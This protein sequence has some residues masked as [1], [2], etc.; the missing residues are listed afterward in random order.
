MGGIRNI[1]GKYEGRRLLGRPKWRWDHKIT[2]KQGISVWNSFIRSWM[3]IDF[4]YS[5]YGTKS[6][7]STKSVDFL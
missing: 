2:Y 6:V 5:E 7:Y 4:E 3:G 1:V